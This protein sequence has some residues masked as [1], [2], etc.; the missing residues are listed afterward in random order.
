MAE[1][2]ELLTP[3]QTVGPFLTMGMEWLADGAVVEATTPGAIRIEGLLTDGA[4]APIPDGVIETWQAG[5]DGTFASAPDAAFS[6]FARSL[7]TA[8]GGF[9][10]T[11]LRPGR[12]EGQAPHLDV[13]VFCR[14]LLQ[15]LLTRIYFSD[16]AEANASDPVLNSVPEA[17]RHLLVAAVDGPSARCNI[18]LQGEA[19]TPFFVF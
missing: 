17:R 8:D 5:P 1:Q 15:R 11:T 19:E 6:G 2:T 10:I 7:T 14:G 3:S 12:V 13:S 4:G 18:S 16:E 9:S